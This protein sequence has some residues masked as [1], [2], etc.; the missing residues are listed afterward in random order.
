M[1]WSAPVLRG[2]GLRLGF[3]RLFSFGVREDPLCVADQG[4]LGWLKGL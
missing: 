3:V 4:A 1:K 2:V